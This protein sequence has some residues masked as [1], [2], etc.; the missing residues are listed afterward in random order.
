LEKKYKMNWPGLTT[1]FLLA[2]FKFMFAPFSGIP[3][4]LG[5]FEICVSS[6]LGGLLSSFVFYFAGNFLL[7]KMGKQK[8]KKVHTRM[9]RF[10]V[11]LKQKLGKI[12]ITFWA[13]FFLSIPI[14]SMVVAKF[15]GKEKGT[16]MFITLGMALN[17][18]VMSMLAYVLS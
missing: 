2:T 16:F 17:S 1:V 13:P 12:G 4:G 5:F 9:N 15:Y 3:F 8:K 6:F 11:K 18:L 14:G 7:K 10:I